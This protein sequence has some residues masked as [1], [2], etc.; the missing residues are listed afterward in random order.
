MVSRVSLDKNIPKYDRIAEVLS[1]K[2]ADRGPDAHGA[3]FQQGSDSPKLLPNWPDNDH[4]LRGLSI[5]P[6]IFLIHRRLSILDITDASNQPLV[7]KCGRFSLVFNGEIYN[8]RAP[9]LN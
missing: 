5:P 3:L 9:S 1:Q 7:S 6:D 4:G 8:F 2:I